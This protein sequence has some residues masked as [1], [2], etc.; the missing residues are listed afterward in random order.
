MSLQGTETLGC[1]MKAFAGESQARQ[2]YTMYAKIAQEEGYLQIS[3]IFA[4]TAHN[5][6][7]HA[8]IFFNHLQAGLEGES[9][10]HPVEIT[11]EYPVGVGTT[12]QNLRYAA[13]GED[14]ENEVVYPQFAEIAKREGFRAIANSFRM[15]GDIEAHHRDRYIALADL[16]ENDA[17][18][19]KTEPVSWICDE[20]GHIHHGVKALKICP[21][22]QYP[23]GHFA[24]L[25]ENY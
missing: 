10:P 24:I 5:E 18:F 9:F 17:I 2:R 19:T 22:C 6:E 4:E 23:Q 1:L 15:I 20:C 12:I 7:R 11:A 25:A 16:A 3:R 21:V 8:K 13:A 14:E